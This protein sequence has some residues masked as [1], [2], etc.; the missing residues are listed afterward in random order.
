[1]NKLL[2]ASVSATAILTLSACNKD[3]PHDMPPADAPATQT[4]V[5]PTMGEMP[6]EVRTVGDMKVEIQAP[7]ARATV[8][9]QNMGG[10]FVNIMTD[11][12]ATL[13]G[14]RSSVSS[15]VELHTMK[16]NDE[17]M[18]MAQVP[19]IE[20]PAN[21]KVELKPG[22]M[23]IML[24][25]LKAPLKEGDTITLQ[26]EIRNAAG[27]TETLDVQTPVKALNDAMGGMNH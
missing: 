16:M 9:G 24:M 12:N 2:L 19:A 23:H 25:D 7:W 26:L 22:S 13:V 11:Q 8:P 3:K 10:A 14:V 6:S 5:A 20:L 4:S 18:I 17:Q 27:Q 15:K 1:M 21:V